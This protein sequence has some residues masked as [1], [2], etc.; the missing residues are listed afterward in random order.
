MRI[1]RKERRANLPAANIGAGADGNAGNQS[2]V[3]IQVDL[4]SGIFITHLLLIFI[5]H[6]FHQSLVGISSHS[7][8][9]DLILPP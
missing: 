4:I 3:S 2:T 1:K 5:T 8:E 9:G 7:G 6:I